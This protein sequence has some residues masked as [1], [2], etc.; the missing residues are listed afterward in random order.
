MPMVFKFAHLVGRRGAALLWFGTLDVF[1]ALTLFNPPTLLTTQAIY[2]YVYVLGG[3][4]FWGV[5]WLLVGLFLYQQAFAKRDSA[6]FA[7]GIMVKV[8]W[9]MLFFAAWLIDQADRAWVNAFLWLFLAGLVLVIAG[10]PEPPEKIK[11]VE[12]REND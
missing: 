8:M 12:K 11:T 10:W 5:V 9:S 6:G 4:Q 3:P 1:I 2:H 7:A